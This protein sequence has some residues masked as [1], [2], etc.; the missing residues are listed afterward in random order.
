MNKLSLSCARS[1]FRN[2]EQQFNRPS[3]FINEIPRYLLKQS[4]AVP[5]KV[6]SS[7]SSSL[8]AGSMGSEK[9]KIPSS[10][11]TGKGGALFAGNPYISKGFGS[12][13]S[14]SGS[15]AA[16][17]Y[18]TGDRV[19]HVRFG[20]GTVTEMKE[21]GSDY[22]VTVAFDNSINRKMMASFAKLKKL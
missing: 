6:S 16:V 15:P 17:N 2:G 9:K 4:G 3:Q 18:T 13:K 7:A 8:N 1:R 21:V 20:E 12:T 14:A 19:A 5:A 11:K 22:Q 10:Q